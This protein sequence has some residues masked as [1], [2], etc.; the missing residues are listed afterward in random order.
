M[1]AAGLRI[2]AV[3]STSSVCSFFQTIHS[4]PKFR[5]RLSGAPLALVSPTSLDN[6]FYA[7]LLLALASFVDAGPVER[8]QLNESAYPVSGTKGPTPKAEWVTTYN[9][10]KA[11]GNI[12][13][14]PP[15]VLSSS[16]MP[17]YPSTVNTSNICAWS[18]TTCIAPN[19]IGAGP[20]GAWGVAFDDG[21]RKG[22]LSLPLPPSPALYTFLQQN[23]QSATHF[24]IG[25]NILDNPTIFQQAVQT[26]GHIAVH[27]FSHPYMTTLT[28]LE[29]VGELGWT[30]Q[31]ML[32]MTGWLP[33]YWR[34]PYGD[35]DNRVRLAVLSLWERT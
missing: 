8:R 15:S 34:P 26:G 18:L 25:S 33:A 5:S 6:M 24:F 23:N 31:I 30:A 16:G 21:V 14:I 27:T 22:P 35:I 3:P 10:A 9:A 29:V 20:N 19:D 11:A 12:P 13:D 17:T 1:G 32:D 28:D 4:T 2:S 7:F